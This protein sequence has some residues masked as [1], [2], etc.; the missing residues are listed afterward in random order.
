MRSRF[1]AP[2]SEFDGCFTSF[3][4][5]DLTVEDGGTICDH[6]QPERAGIRSM[7]GSR[8]LA[9]LGETS[10]GRPPFAAS[11]PSSLPTYFE[12]GSTRLLGI[13]FMPLG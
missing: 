11:G 2:P 12:I 1:F 9:Q 3:Y 6:L 10:V 8:P 5:L 4:H 7:A 13:G